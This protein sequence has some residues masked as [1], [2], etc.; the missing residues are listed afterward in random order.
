VRVGPGRASRPGEV[1]VSI[2]APPSAYALELEFE[3]HFEPA[4]LRFK[5]LRPC[6]AREDTLL[7]RAAEVRPGV[8]RIA[9]AGVRPIGRTRLLAAFATAAGTPTSVDD[10][11]AAAVVMDE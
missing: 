6:G 2:A 4:R 9:A 8:V 1:R 10:V 7:L 5:R 3:L 11:R